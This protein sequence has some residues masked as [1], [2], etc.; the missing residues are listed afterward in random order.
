MHMVRSVKS[1]SSVSKS[2][3][4]CEVARLIADD[5]I[6]SGSFTSNCT[7]GQREMKRGRLAGRALRPHPATVRLDQTLR[8]VETDP[9]SRRTRSARP[10]RA[11]EPREDPR[12]IFRSDALA[13]VRHRQLHFIIVLVELH[14]NLGLLVAVFH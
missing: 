7:A 2:G 13:M 3:P 5:A 1:V 9:K 4:P 11:H 8:D 12:Q 14:Q 6:A 10:F